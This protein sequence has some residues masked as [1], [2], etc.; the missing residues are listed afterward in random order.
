MEPTSPPDQRSLADAQLQGATL[1]AARALDAYRLDAYIP[2]RMVEEM[3]GGR[4]LARL[5]ARKIARRVAPRRYAVS[6]AEGI[7]TSYAGIAVFDRPDQHKGGM[8]SG[9]DFPRVLN[10]LGVGRCERLLEYCAGPGYIGYSLLAAGWC[11]T[12]ALADIDAG[13]VATARRTASFNGL[14]ERVSVYESDGLDQIPADDTWDLVVAN[15][16]H[17]LPTPDTPDDVQV[18]DPDWQAHRK[19]YGSAKRHMRPGGRVLMAENCAGSDPDV[20]AEMIVRGGGRPVAA[21]E[22]TD[23][24]GKPNGLYYQLSEW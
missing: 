20:F 13:A 8:A 9:Q 18:F 4:A 6:S 24:H 21:H 16:P 15:P 2:E 12:L 10:E 23:V 3:Y 22:G 11:E 7:V 14:E 17:F 1:D 19:F 5:L